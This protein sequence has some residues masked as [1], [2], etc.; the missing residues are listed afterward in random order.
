MRT[1]TVEAAAAFERWNG[2]HW[3][4][5]PSPDEYMDAPER[6]ADNAC[7]ECEDGVIVVVG[8]EYGQTMYACHRCPWSS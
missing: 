2:S 8:M 6:T 3:V 1:S 4:D 5:A 7:P